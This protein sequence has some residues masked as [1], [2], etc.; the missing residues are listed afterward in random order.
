MPP[1]YPLLSPGGFPLML[2]RG[3][4][5]GLWSSQDQGAQDLKEHTIP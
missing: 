4:V 5:R 3:Y 2:G 1:S